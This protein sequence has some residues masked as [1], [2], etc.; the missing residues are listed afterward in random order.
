MRMG[1]Y[2]LLRYTHIDVSSFGRRK[3]RLPDKT[4]VAWYNGIKNNIV[5]FISIDVQLYK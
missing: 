5:T 1:F 3:C 4:I 2:S